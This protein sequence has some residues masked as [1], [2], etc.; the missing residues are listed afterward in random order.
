MKTSTEIREF[1][2]PIKTTEIG[3]HPSFW[4]MVNQIQLRKSKEE[5]QIYYGL[6]GGA[7]NCR[8]C[9]LLIKSSTKQNLWGHEDKCNG[10]QKARHFLTQNGKYFCYFGCGEFEDR[11]QLETHYTAE[12][13][14]EQ[15]SIFGITLKKTQIQP[16]NQEIHEA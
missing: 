9:N 10:K 1:K 15:L 5:K 12:H 4:K 7:Q 14:D 3:K 11:R 6:H 13:T 16:S 2:G 8:K